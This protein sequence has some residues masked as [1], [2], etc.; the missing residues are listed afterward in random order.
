VG[1]NM[2]LMVTLWYPSH[3]T[4]KLGEIVPKMPKIP[5]YIK[6]WKIYQTPAGKNGFKQYHLMFIEKGKGDDALVDVGKIL[7]PFWEQEGVD[8]TIEPVYGQKDSF[9]VFA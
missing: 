4:A 1:S 5:D 3:L 8:L 7:R 9:K 2:I 6:K